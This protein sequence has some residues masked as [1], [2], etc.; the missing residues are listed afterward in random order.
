MLEQAGPNLLGYGERYF[1][2]PPIQEKSLGQL[3]GG[4]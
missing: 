3:K 4:S 2:L 1:Q